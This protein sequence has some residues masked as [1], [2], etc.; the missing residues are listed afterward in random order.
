MRTPLWF[1][2]PE[3]IIEP[4]GSDPDFGLRVLNVAE[5]YD[6]KIIT[7]SQ[8]RSLKLGRI[9]WWKGKPNR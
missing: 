5:Q 2:A 1:A 4:D 3:Y 9:N 7:L 6:M 8:A